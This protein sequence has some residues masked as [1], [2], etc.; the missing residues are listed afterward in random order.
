MI[1]MDNLVKL[2]T[3]PSNVVAKL[4]EMRKEF[5]GD[6]KPDFDYDTKTRLRVSLPGNMGKM[7]N[8]IVLEQPFLIRDK[9]GIIFDRN[10][11]KK[12][13]NMCSLI[14]VQQDEGCSDSFAEVVRRDVMKKC[15]IPNLYVVIGGKSSFPNSVSWVTEGTDVSGNLSVFVHVTDLFFCYTGDGPRFA[16]SSYSRRDYLISMNKIQQIR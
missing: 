3:L 8:R 7:A 11:W 5:E 2:N 12:L 13:I 1:E 10:D 9:K 14:G 16:D 6:Y 15:G 4:N